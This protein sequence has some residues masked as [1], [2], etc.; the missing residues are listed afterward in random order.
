MLRTWLPLGDTQPNTH[1]T[2][3][4]TP[5]PTSC[6]RFRYAEMLTGLRLVSL[7]CGSLIPSYTGKADRPRASLP[8][9]TAWAHDETY[10]REQPAHSSILAPIWSREN[11]SHEFHH[12]TEEA[13]LFERASIKG[14]PL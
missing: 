5:H 11:G 8:S 14:G 6:G 7:V 2:N 13:E 9:S 10:G 12:L 3:A 1:Y 4:E